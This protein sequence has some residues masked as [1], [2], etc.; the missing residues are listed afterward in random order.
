MNDLWGLQTN[1]FLGLEN[2]KELHVYMN[3]WLGVETGAF[4][5]TGA[6]AG[7]DSLYGLLFFEP[8]VCDTL[9]ATGK[10]PQSLSRTNCL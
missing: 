3:D 10:L 8:S 2:L 6:F 4:I 7:L 9:F 5:E 1:T